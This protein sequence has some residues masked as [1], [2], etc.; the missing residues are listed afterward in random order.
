MQSK[1]HNGRHVIDTEEFTW[2][3]VKFS[4][5]IWICS[6]VNQDYEACVCYSYPCFYFPC[7]WPCI[8][9]HS[10]WIL[11][12]LGMHSLTLPLNIPCAWPCIPW[13]SPWTFPVHGHAFPDFPLQHS[14]CM[15]MHSLT[16]SMNIPYAWPY[17][18]WHSP[19][20]FPVHDHAFPDIPHEHSLC[21]AM[22]SLIFPLNIP[23]TWSCIPWHTLCM[24]MH[25]LT[26]LLNIP[27][28]WPCF[29]WHTLCMV[30]HSLTF[31]W[32]I[33]PWT[34]P[35]NCGTL[36]ALIPCPA[37]LRCAGTKA[38]RSKRIAGDPTSCTS[39]VQS[40]Y[41]TICMTMPAIAEVQVGV[42]PVLY[43][44]SGSCIPTVALC[45]S[46]VSHDRG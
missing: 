45:L 1:T 5:T 42:R 8:P 43:P 15:T 30:M 19:W 11:P 16:F 3:N 26:F 2:K 7:A 33:F 40:W 32:N 13:H 41:L 27:S 29:P 17:I 34:T 44:F 4:L 21:M 14:L 20:T 24:A 25:S 36:Q 31:P 10:N 6:I 39:V 46:R 37:V 28:V 22:H 18:P 23:C 38:L 12:V 9:W 35:V